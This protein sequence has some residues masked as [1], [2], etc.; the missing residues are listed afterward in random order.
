MSRI[1]PS[2]IGRRGESLSSKPWEDERMDFEQALAC[3]VGIRSGITVREARTLYELAI[4]ARRSGSI[5]EIGSY[6]G[7]STILLSASGPV[8]AIDHHRGSVEHQPGQPRCRP[9]TLVVDQVD[10]YPIFKANLTRATLWEHVIPVVTDHITA[11]QLLR[12][13]V[14]PIALLFVDADHSELGTRVVIDL[15]RDRVQGVIAFHD[16]S[17]DFPGVMKAVDGAGF[18]APYVLDDS[19][20]AFRLS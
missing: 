10:T 19:L 16:Y 6:T 14:F 18:G 12:A 20:I 9:G 7:K 3:T 4:V 13:E 1:R 8:Y 5:V 17:S 11:L 2:Q 15:W